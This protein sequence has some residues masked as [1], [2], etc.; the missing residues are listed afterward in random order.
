MAKLLGLSFKI[1]MTDCNWSNNCTE[2]KPEIWKIATRSSKMQHT[3][4]I[5]FGNNLHHNTTQRYYKCW[6]L[7]WICCPGIGRVIIL[8]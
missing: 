7:E 2:I 1:E 6:S 4:S 5:K 8:K 3:F